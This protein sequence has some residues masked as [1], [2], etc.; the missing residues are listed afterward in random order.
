MGDLC[1]LGTRNMSVRLIARMDVKGPNLVKG[2]RMEGL[3]VLGVPEEF[4][5]H[6]YEGGADELFLIDAVA[7]LYGR[8][9]LHD[10]IEKTSRA[11]FIPLTVGGGLRNLKDVEGVLR[12]GA[13][14]VALNSAALA[15][16]ALVRE[17]AQRFGSSTIVIAID[18]IR[19]PNG[20][21]EAYADYG[22][23]STGKNAVEWA[24]EVVELGAGELLI[25][26]IDREGTGRGFDLD[27]TL[28]IAHS[29]PV[30][31]IAGGGAGN[32]V[33]VVEVIREGGADAVALASVLHYKAL[34]DLNKSPHAEGNQEFLTRGS[35]F[36]LVQSTTLAELKSLLRDHGIDCR[37]AEV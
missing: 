9:S 32:A 34:S 14:K 23:E 4:A 30:P 37:P 28:A 1:G 20:L 33:H 24:R 15:R 16:P 3:R 26:S 17:A 6:Y 35:G 12:A 5:R 21:Y 8:N 27:L 18:A 31:V 29:V 2:V 25:T 36:R 22:R 10:I 19:R 11:T 13:D 7:S